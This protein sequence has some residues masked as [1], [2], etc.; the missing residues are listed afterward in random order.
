MNKK[1]L[2]IILGSIA[3]VLMGFGTYYYFASEDKNTTLTKIEREWIQSNKQNL[4]DLGF[5]NDIP[6]LN[7][8]GEGLVFD[9]FKDLEDSTE[10]EFNRISYSYNDEITDKYSFKMIKN[11]E[12]NQIKIYEDDYVLLTTENKKY[13]NVNEI[14]DLNIGVLEGDLTEVKNYFN[15]CN[16]CKFNGFKSIEELLNNIVGEENDMVETTLDAIIAPQ[17]LTLEYVLSDK[18]Y[19][20]YL[21]NDIHINY[22]ITLG[23]IN[24]L[25]NIIKK[26]YLKWSSENFDEKFNKYFTDCYFDFSGTDQNSLASF[27]GKRYTYGYIENA[28][29]DIEI[30]GNLYGTNKAILDKFEEVADIE[31]VYKK[32]DSID[33][34]I[35]AFNNGNIDIFYNNTYQSGYD[36]N[37]FVSNNA[38]LGKVAIISNN[39]AIENI[40]SLKSLKNKSIA[41]LKNSNISKLVTDNGVK[42]VEY[43][44]LD[45]LL[46]SNADLIAIDFSSY[47]F[48]NKDKLKNYKIEYIHEV[49]DGYGYTMKSV[50]NNSVFNEYLNFYLNAF[51]QN[52][53]I[54][55]GIDKINSKLNQK[56]LMK[57]LFLI[58]GLILVFVSSIIFTNQMNKAK[59]PSISFKK[60]EKI[61]YMDMLTSL[62]NRNYLNDNIDKWEESQVYP[63]A[64]IIIDLN[65][66]A[67]INDNYGHNAGD[68]EIKEAANVLIKNQVI[69]SDIV[70][71]NGN[72]FLIYLIGYKERQIE[73]YI[74]KLNK[75]LK[76]LSH[77]F[78]AAIGYSMITDDIK[79]IDDAI[80]EA[81]IAMRQIK[82]ETN[83]QKDL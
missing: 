55:L 22:V 63:Q 75:E 18:L 51:A 7:H 70:R 20:S 60:S 39:G 49:I 74:K 9:F 13:N 38:Y 40:N 34:L 58:S 5:A 50:A 10:L 30:S 46:K 48:F 64:V 16:G 41:V 4:I 80:N 54:G 29:Y 21:I 25:N 12:S 24:K 81:T 43:D 14:E 28:P 59:K 53:E 23:N 71:T 68:E 17:L 37:G 45:K 3:L 2:F 6:V 27:K 57:D 1:V 33:S 11:I 36:L 52:E 31:I 44:S 8:I 66:I 26:Y 82:E 19:N 77:G 42:K 78:G 69:N 56:A 47:N 61:K 65:N 62:K 35:K 15:N 72:E 83:D 79:T 76:E 73:L 67:Y 32:Y